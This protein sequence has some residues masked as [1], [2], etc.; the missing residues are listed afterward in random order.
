M[1]LYAHSRYYDKGKP[2]DE[3][4]SVVNISRGGACLSFQKPLAIGSILNMEFSDCE[5]GFAN[6]LLEWSKIHGDMVNLRVQ[7][8]VLRNE[9]FD[10]QF[11]NHRIAIKFNSP[12]HILGY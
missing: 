3:H 9:E 10:D 1:P 4:M 11:Q 6:Q 12:I 7:G 5:S 8:E 2:V